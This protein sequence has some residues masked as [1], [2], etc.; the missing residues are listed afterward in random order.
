MCLSRFVYESPSSKEGEGMTHTRRRRKINVTKAI[1]ISA[2]EPDSL[3]WYVCDMS[4]DILCWNCEQNQA[5]KLLIKILFGIPHI[6]AGE[7]DSRLTIR[8]VYILPCS[9]PHMC[10]DGEISHQ[11]QKQLG[12]TNRW[13]NLFSYLEQ[14]FKSKSHSSLNLM[15]VLKFQEQSV[16]EI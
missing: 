9:S 14:H 3:V 2:R 12:D 13:S 16:K 11:Q 15:K 6:F 4:V 7:R 5:Q 8:I 1:F 10:Y